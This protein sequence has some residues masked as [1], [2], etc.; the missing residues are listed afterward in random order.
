MDGMQGIGVAGLSA[1]TLTSLVVG[2]RLIALYRRTHQLP[3]LAMGLSFFT[4]GF[5][6]TA[7]N[8]FGNHAQADPVVA[9]W[10]RLAAALISYVGY[11]L[12]AF[13]VWRVFRRDA[14]GA[15][16]FSASAVPLAAGFAMQAVST[17]P[18]LP[19][20]IDAGFWVAFAGQVIA[21]GWAAAETLH[22]WVLLRRRARIGLAEPLLVNRF[23]LWGIANATVVGIWAEVA[24]SM[25]GHETAV[26]SDASYLRMALLGFAC[27]ATTWLAFFPPRRYARR[28]ERARGARGA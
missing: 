22:Y 5:L 12:M 28:F 20:P 15:A 10:L 13:F 24:W 1:F 4:S 2:L 7:M 16:L 18:V 14:A 8:L 6:S 17:R 21:Y 11:A 3:E 27:A 9:M 23:L 25:A 26:I 19:A